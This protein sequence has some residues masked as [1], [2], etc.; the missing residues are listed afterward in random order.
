MQALVCEQ[1][2]LEPHKGGVKI[3]IV[4]REEAVKSHKQGASL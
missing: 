1:G 3:R 4:G 2:K